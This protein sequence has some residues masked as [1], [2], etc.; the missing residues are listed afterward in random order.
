MALANDPRRAEE[1]GDTNPPQNGTNGFDT[2][3]HTH[4][5]SDGND[6]DGGQEHHSGYVELNTAEPDSP[7]EDDEEDSPQT[8]DEIMRSIPPSRQVEEM[9]EESNRTH[10][11]EAIQERESLFNQTSTSSVIEMNKDRVDSIRAAMAG[12]QLPP[13]AIPSWASNMSEEDWQEKIS[14]VLQPRK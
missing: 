7:G 4:S 8:L 10:E 6:S 1:N 12:F 3:E 5:E 9:I 13:N 11:V 2:A 14:N